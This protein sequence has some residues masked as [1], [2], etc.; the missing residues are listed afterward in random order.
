MTALLERRTCRCSSSLTLSCSAGIRRPIATTESEP[1]TEQ[2][3]IERR[4]AAI[5][6]HFRSENHC[7][8]SGAGR[9]AGTMYLSKLKLTV[10][11]LWPES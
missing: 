11:F 10:G 2:N 8:P 3:A 1:F 6:E 4:Q 5:S 7:N 9:P